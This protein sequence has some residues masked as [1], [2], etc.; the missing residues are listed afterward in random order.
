[1]RALD[2][3]GSNLVGERTDGVGTRHRSAYRF[4]N[5][6]PDA[7][8]IVVSQDGVVRFVKKKDDQVT[9]WEHASSGGEA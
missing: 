4:C 5:A 1:M 9:Y 2:V 6:Y 3:E 8:A 7:L